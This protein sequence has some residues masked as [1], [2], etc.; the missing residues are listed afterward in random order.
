MPADTLL[1]I[2]WNYKPFSPQ[3]HIGHD[4][5]PWIHISAEHSD[6][7]R[8]DGNS[9]YANINENNLDWLPYAHPLIT[10]YFCHLFP[11]NTHLS[12]STFSYKKFHHDGRK[13]V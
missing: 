6:M 8:N 10:K 3:N 13:I 7:K 4:H 5:C 9:Q 12:K 2:H 11:Y 1:K